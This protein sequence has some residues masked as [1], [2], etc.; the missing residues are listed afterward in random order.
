MNTNLARVNYI[1]G[2]GGADCPGAS[3]GGGCVEGY[4][5]GGQTNYDQAVEV[6]VWS[7]FHK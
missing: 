6:W 1:S 5:R 7:R 3:R 4:Q 2:G